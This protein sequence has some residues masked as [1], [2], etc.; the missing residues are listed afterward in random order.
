MLSNIE[1]EDSDNHV[2]TTDSEDEEKEEEKNDHDSI[3]T[4]NKENISSIV[5]DEESQKK[6]TTVGIKSENQLNICDSDSNSD[7]KGEILLNKLY[8][9]LFLTNSEIH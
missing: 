3:P 4:G 7:I 1:G 5:N 2:L 8:K 9:D 6:E